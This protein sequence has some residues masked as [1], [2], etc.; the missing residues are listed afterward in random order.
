MKSK[1]SLVSTIKNSKFNFTKNSLWFWLA[2]VVLVV[3]SL[4]VVIFAGFNYSIDITGGAVISARLGYQVEQTSDYNAAVKDIT[5]ILNN[6][7]ISGVSVKKQGE[8]DNTVVI[9]E[10]KNKSGKDAEY[11][12]TLI[13]EV[14]TQIN[15][16]YNA[17]EFDAIDG[18]FD[19]TLGSGITSPSNLKNGLLFNAIVAILFALSILLLYISIRFGVLAGLTALL[20]VVHDI[21]LTLAIVAITRISVT[22]AIFGAVAA[23]ATFSLINSL[24]TFARI[25]ENLKSPALTNKT[26]QEIATLSLKQSIIRVVAT[27]VAMLLF[28]ILF[29]IVG[30]AFIRHF[31]AIIAI[32]TLVSFYSAMFLLPAFWANV[33]HKRDLSKPKAVIEVQEPTLNEKDDQ[34]EVIEV[35]D[36]TK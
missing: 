31:F 11:M 1:Q 36:E 5:A 7:G 29:V 23:V 17:T 18:D 22:T 34:A 35:K 24:I 19:I 13:D 14:R 30:P 9:F 21:L 10:F 27:T 2:S 33:N 28:A 4:F 3:A 12:Q 6:R 8:A 26:N 25:K 15:L 20:G 16:K 32:G